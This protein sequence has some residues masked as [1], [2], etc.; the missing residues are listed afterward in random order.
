MPLTKV[1]TTPLAIRPISSVCGMLRLQ[2]VRRNFTITN[3]RSLTYLHR[4]IALPGST[5]ASEDERHPASE[6]RTSELFSIQLGSGLD[7]YLYEET[8]F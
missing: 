5:A 6:Q 3:A 1:F 2:L 4:K 8:S 7:G